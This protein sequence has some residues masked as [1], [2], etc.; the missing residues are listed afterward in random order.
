[1]ASV[2]QR[3]ELVG[4][5]ATSSAVGVA[6][7]ADLC[8][9]GASRRVEVS[10]VVVE[11]SASPAAAAGLCN[12]VWRSREPWRRVASVPPVGCGACRRV[13]VVGAQFVPDKL[14]VFVGHGVLL[15]AV[16]R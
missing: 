14:T 1:M 7:G 2:H 8:G 10:G 5:S 9:R 3:R 4:A 6:A 12:A 11:A 16:Y 13:G 15:M